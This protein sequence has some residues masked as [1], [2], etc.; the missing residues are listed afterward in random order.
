MKFV[1]HLSARGPTLTVAL[2]RQ[3]PL[4]GVLIPRFFDGTVLARQMN[5]GVLALTYIPSLTDEP[6][7]D[8]W[9]D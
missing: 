3:W 9:N 2:G 4:F 6:A 1:W 7:E 8:P 5:L